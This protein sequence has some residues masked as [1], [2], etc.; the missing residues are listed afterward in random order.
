MK[1][2]KDSI[3]QMQVPLMMIVGTGLQGGVTIIIML[4]GREGSDRMVVQLDGDGM[5]PVCGKMQI[6]WW[7]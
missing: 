6:S 5:D 2:D 3:L 1:G 4:S 7:L